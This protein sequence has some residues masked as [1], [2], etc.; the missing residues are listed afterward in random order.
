MR[1]PRK[2]LTEQ[3]NKFVGGLLSGT[4]HNEDNLYGLHVRNNNGDQ[5]VAYGDAR[6]Y[7]HVN[8]RNL[9]IMIKAVQTSVQEVYDAFKSG[10]TPVKY[11]VIDYLP[12][13]ESMINR[14]PMF[15][16]ENDTLY[17]RKQ[18]FDHKIFD[19]SFVKLRY[20]LALLIWLQFDKDTRF[21]S[22]DDML[23]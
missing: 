2:E 16:L 20:P 21:W 9:E 8:R 15:I 22:G 7:D 19:G 3:S 13:P 11:G 14:T 6:G 12:H 17:R 1:V 23:R 5:W 4:M 10:N 18:I